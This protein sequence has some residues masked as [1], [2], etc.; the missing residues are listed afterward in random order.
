M[1]RKG[2]TL[3]EFLGCMAIL[4]VVLGLGLYST[5][6][7]LSTTLSTLT[8]VSE[9]Q[10][11]DAAKTYVL[12]YSNSWINDGEEYTCVSV[13]TLVDVG[14]FEESEVSSYKHNMIRVVRD[15]KTQTINSVKLV[16][17]CN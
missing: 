12:E 10:I 14:Y 6:G 8:G 4:A 1:N 9:S 17:E 13:N 2:F 7:T 15:A 3:I 5:R 11:L 16:E